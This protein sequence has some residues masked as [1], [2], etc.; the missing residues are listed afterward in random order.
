MTTFEEFEKGLVYDPKKDEELTKSIVLKEQVWKML[1]P[2]QKEAIGNKWPEDKPK[3]KM[4]TPKG[5]LT[6]A[7]RED[8]I[9][10]LQEEST[11][12]QRAEMAYKHTLYGLTDGQRRGIRDDES[13]E[14]LRY[15]ANDSRNRHRNLTTKP[16]SK[17]GV[18]TNFHA[19]QSRKLAEKSQSNT[20]TP[21]L[22]QEP[23]L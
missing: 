2:G 3:S 5:Y 20:A 22:E 18:P 9:R 10:A 15:R 6:D 13:D 23:T 12:K 1:T 14:E 16:P 21:T 7:E 8:Y 4:T 19:T 11:P 17:T